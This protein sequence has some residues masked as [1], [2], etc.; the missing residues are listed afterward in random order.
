MFAGSRKAALSSASVRLC[1]VRKLIQESFS[2]EERGAILTTH[3]MEEAD[4]LCS[5]IAI[6]VNGRMQ[7]VAIH[8]CVRA[9]ARVCVSV[10]SSRSSSYEA[11][12]LPVLYY[13]IGYIMCHQ[14]SFFLEKNL[15]SKPFRRRSKTYNNLMYIIVSVL[16]LNSDRDVDKKSSQMHFQIGIF[17]TYKI[18]GSFMQM[19]TSFTIIHVAMWQTMYDSTM[20]W[21]QVHRNVAASQESVR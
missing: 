1:C 7:W 6:M 12:S 3:Y 21:S 10:R 16:L 19:F 8:V 2:G 11:L 20:P 14:F 15:S 9:C 17:Q 18:V 13:C 5:R 4:T